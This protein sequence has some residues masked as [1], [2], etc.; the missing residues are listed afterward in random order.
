MLVSNG[1]SYATGTPTLFVCLFVM[2]CYNP[3]NREGRVVINFLHLCLP[4]LVKSSSDRLLG[5]SPRCTRNIVERASPPYKN[6][7]KKGKESL[8]KE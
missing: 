5:V 6:T 7:A 3:V 2:L 8:L 4:R 1:N